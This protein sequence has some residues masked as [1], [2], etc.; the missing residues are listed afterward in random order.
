M[1]LTGRRMQKREGKGKGCS[2]T[3]TTNHPQVLDLVAS[4]IGEMTCREQ[5]GGSKLHAVNACSRQSPYFSLSDR[6]RGANISWRS[7]T[8][9]DSTWA[10]TPS[11]LHVWLEIW[12]HYCAC[13]ATMTCV[14]TVGGMPTACGCGLDM[15]I[16][17]WRKA[18]LKLA[19][20]EATR[21]EERR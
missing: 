13:H 16:V 4:N 17:S 7:S 18:L 1:D 10:S 21:Y 6:C 20:K 8:E 14:D 5:S 19:R 11:S 9:R 15:A 12:W 2:R 3:T